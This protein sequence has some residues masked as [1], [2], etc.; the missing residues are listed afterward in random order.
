MTAFAPID[1]GKL[2]QGRIRDFG[3]RHG[4]AKT[5]CRPERPARVS[6]ARRTLSG[7]SRDCPVVD[8]RVPSSPASVAGQP[9]APFGSKSAV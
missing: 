9:L 1:G 4:L 2:G 3:S 6:K 7:G 8:R 5:S